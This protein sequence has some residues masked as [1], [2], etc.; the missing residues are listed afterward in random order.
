MKKE[1]AVWAKTAIDNSFVKLIIPQNELVDSE[2]EVRKVP[3]EAQQSATGTNHHS[4]Y[5]T[6][7]NTEPGV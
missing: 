7:I 3:E 5:F 6:I 4:L 2:F 1:T